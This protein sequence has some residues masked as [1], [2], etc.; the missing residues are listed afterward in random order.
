[1]GKCIIS[2]IFLVVFFL[3]GCKILD[4]K[5]STVV[6]NRANINK[7]FICESDTSICNEGI[8]LGASKFDLS[9]ENFKFNK[10]SRTV[11]ANMLVMDNNDSVPDV[12]IIIGKLQ[13]NTLIPL[14]IIGITDK[15]GI[16]S[17]KFK[18]SSNEIIYLFHI[19]YYP[20]LFKVTVTKDMR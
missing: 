6:F 13:N 4:N 3:Y 7:N 15:R 14:K 17:V 18:L 9:I 2:F 1:M 12:R 5:V 20:I 19:G 8:V 11:S 16:V 10:V